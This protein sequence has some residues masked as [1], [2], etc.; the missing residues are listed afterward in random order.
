MDAWVNLNDDRIP[1]VEITPT[2]EPFRTSFDRRYAIPT[3]KLAQKR[4]YMGF[5]VNVSTDEL[6]KAEWVSETEGVKMLEEGRFGNDVLRVRVPE[7]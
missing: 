6:N 5:N 2:F 4:E 1:Y 7:N 3:A